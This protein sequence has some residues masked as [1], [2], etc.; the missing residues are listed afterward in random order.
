MWP[1]NDSKHVYKEEGLHSYA[2]IFYEVLREY[3]QRV[4]IHPFRPSQ[5]GTS[6]SSVPHALV[7]RV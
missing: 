6:V 7:T 2:R 5:L 3:G 4:A 1:H